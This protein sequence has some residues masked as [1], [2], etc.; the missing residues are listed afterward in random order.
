MSPHNSPASPVLVVLGAG[1]HDMRAFALEQIA[2]VHPV[3]LMDTAP[4]G[5][6]LAPRRRP[7]GHQPPRP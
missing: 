4:P 6:G 3:L 5:M 7:M 2:A 1:D